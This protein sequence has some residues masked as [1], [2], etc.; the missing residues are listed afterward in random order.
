MESNGVRQFPGFHLDAD[1]LIEVSRNADGH[2]PFDAVQLGGVGGVT[3][4]FT[5]GSL[6]ALHRLGQECLKH[7]FNRKIENKNLAE[8][9]TQVVGVKV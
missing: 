4:Y 8:V 2:T 3:L 5:E 6:E 1:V 9:A 7:Y